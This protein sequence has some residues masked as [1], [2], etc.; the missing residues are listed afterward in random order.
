MKFNNIRISIF[1][2]EPILNFINDLSIHYNEIQKHFLN[3]LYLLILKYMKI[4]FFSHEQLNLQIN[5][6]NINL[7]YL[8]NNNLMCL[9]FLKTNSFCLGNI[10]LYHQLIYIAIIMKLKILIII[11]LLILLKYFLIKMISSTIF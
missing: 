5:S 8:Y 10:F 7:N 9:N 4:Y 3:K 2:S 1:I 6:I 11:L